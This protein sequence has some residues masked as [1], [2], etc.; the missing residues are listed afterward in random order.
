MQAAILHRYRQNYHFRFHYFSLLRRYSQQTL[1]KLFSLAFA[2]Y[3]TLLYVHVS[4]FPDGVL[5]MKLLLNQAL[6]D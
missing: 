2:A 1:Y 3:N 6:W 5:R 4:V